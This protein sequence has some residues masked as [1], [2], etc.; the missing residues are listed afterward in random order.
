[1]LVVLQLDSRAMLVISRLGKRALK[2]CCSLLLKSKKRKR[3]N[4]GLYKYAYDFLK[5][6]TV[7]ECQP[8]AVGRGYG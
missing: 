3:T 1:M 6:F 4:A 2:T 7:L 5:I 8:L